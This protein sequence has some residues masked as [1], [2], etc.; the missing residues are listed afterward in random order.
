MSKQGWDNVEKM[1]GK[2]TAD[3]LK[4]ENILHYVI[5]SPSKGIYLGGGVWSR[6][7]KASS[8]HFA[9]TYP[10][11]SPTNAHFVGAGGENTVPLPKDYEFRL[12]NTDVGGGNASKVACAAAGLEQW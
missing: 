4:V 7:E 2:E 9:I 3:S 8:I 10:E 6:D 5:Y 11:G 12:V 1:V